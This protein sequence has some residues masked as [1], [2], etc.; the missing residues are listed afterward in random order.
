MKNMLKDVK[1]VRDVNATAAG[2]TAIN[3]TVI[4]MAGF[5][6][7]RA[8]AL[9]GALTA[10]QVTSLKLQFGNLANGSDMADVTLTDGTAP[11]TGNA[12]DADSNKLLIVDVVKPSGYRYVRAV[13]NR[14]TANAVVDGVIIDLYQAMSCPVSQDATYVSSS[15]FGVGKTP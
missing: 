3:G 14:A 13:V 1:T 7:V 6:A 8:T 2:T 5:D 9:M 15:K 12:A 4:D 10:T 11:Q